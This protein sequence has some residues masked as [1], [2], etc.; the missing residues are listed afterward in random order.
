MEGVSGAGEAGEVAEI[1][2][3]RAD[4][5]VRQ[6]AENW[7]PFFR[8][9]SIVANS[10]ANIDGL[11]TGDLILKFGTITS[12]NFS[13]EGIQSVLMN[14]IN[15]PIS[16]VVRRNPEGMITFDVTPRQWEGRGHLGCNMVP[17]DS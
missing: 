17:V 10:P 1:K 16:L 14:S 9:E 13:T 3:S 12:Q 7:E 2:E 11:K 5:A 8:V 4:L 6:A 15:R